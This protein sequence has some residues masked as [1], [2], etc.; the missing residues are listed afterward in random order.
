MID[1]GVVL[2]KDLFPCL[3]SGFSSNQFSKGSCIHLGFLMLFITDTPFV[4]LRKYIICRSSVGHTAIGHRQ[5]SYTTVYGEFAK[6]VDPICQEIMG[7]IHLRSGVLPFD[8]PWD[9]GKACRET[10]EVELGLFPGSVFEGR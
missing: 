5:R 6:W 9:I 4:M 2:V 3:Y 7:Y 8:Q 10:R 1:E